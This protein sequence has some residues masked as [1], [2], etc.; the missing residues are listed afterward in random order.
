ME[1]APAVQHTYLLT[2]YNTTTNS[3]EGDSANLAE[4]RDIVAR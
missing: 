2:D 3:S 4:I 1:R